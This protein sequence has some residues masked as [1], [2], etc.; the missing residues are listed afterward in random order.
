MSSSSKGSKTDKS[1]LNSFGKQGKKSWV[2]D[3]TKEV[4]RIK[5]SKFRNFENYNCWE[6]IIC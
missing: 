5:I 6:F 1:S 3:N 2:S 4:L